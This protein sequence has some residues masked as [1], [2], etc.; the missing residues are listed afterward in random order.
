MGNRAALLICGTLALSGVISKGED[1]SAV[2]VRYSEQSFGIPSASDEQNG[3]HYKQ[4]KDPSG[5]QTVTAS[6]TAS[7]TTLNAYAIASNTGLGNGI[8]GLSGNAYARAVAFWTDLIHVT[9]HSDKVVRLRSLL[10]YNGYLSEMGDKTQYFLKA[11]PEAVVSVGLGQ[12]IFSFDDRKYLSPGSFKGS[13]Q[14]AGDRATTIDEMKLTVRADVSA[15]IASA[16]GF[17]ALAR[18]V[19]DANAPQPTNP[20]APA[21]AADT[22]A[23][24]VSILGFEALDAEGN[25]LPPDS[26]SLTADSG[27]TYAI[28]PEPR[29]L[30]AFGIGIILLTRSRRFATRELP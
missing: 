9:Y 21:F 7:M 26:I 4:L 17:P 16:Y 11:E 28:L 23:L 2:Y 1:A 29:F 14:V 8:D 20:A 13:L 15:F 24:G 22:P 25:V 18:A 19:M 5:A 30:A 27:A 6:A 12:G 10:N 3:T